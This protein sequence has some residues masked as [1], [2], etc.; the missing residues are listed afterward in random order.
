METVVPAFALWTTGKVPVTAVVSIVLDGGCESVAES[1]VDLRT[2]HLR[3]EI[4]AGSGT[5][6]NGGHR[7]L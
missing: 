4:L 5:E 6:N 2:K 1:G 3:R 7:G